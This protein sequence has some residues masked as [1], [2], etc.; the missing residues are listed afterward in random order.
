MTF[1]TTI[2]CGTAHYTASSRVPVGGSLTKLA[3]CGARAGVYG[4]YF[5]SSRASDALVGVGPLFVCSGG[6]W[7]TGGIGFPA[8]V[9]NLLSSRAAFGQPRSALRGVGGRECTY[10][11][12]LACIRIVS[13]LCGSSG[14]YAACVVCAISPVRESLARGAS[15]GSGLGRTLCCSATAGIFVIRAWGACAIGCSRAGGV[16]LTNRARTVR[17]CRAYICASIVRL[18]KSLS[19]SGTAI[20]RRC[21]AIC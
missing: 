11:T 13:Q 7:L 21:T 1:W 9:S 4:G 3:S 6:A 10:G 2:D 5:G 19:T 14:A 12:R 16:I 17:V 20:V 8:L 15:S 18:I